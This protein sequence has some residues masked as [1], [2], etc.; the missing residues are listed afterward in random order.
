MFDARAERERSRARLERVAREVEQ[1]LLKP[2]R[3]AMQIRH[4]GVVVVTQLRRR[5]FGLQQIG[6]SFQ[7]LMD[8]HRPELRH[9]VVM[10]QTI[11][12]R[13]E[14]VRFVDDHAG[15]RLQI[16]VVDAALQQ[17][18][19]TAQAGQ[20]I[21]HFMREATQRGRQRRAGQQPLD[22][23]MH[24]EQHAAVE[25]LQRHIREHLAAVCRHQCDAT[26]LQ[27]PLFLQ[28]PPGLRRRVRIDQQ[29][30]ERQPDRAARPHLQLLGQG[31]V[32]PA[33]TQVRVD[34]RQPGRQLLRPCTPVRIAHCTMMGNALVWCK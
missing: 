25:R 22:Q 18:R 11:G 1:H 14:P 21:L 13:A 5:R 17:L 12:E 16:L 24:L 23:R 31:R 2:V 4:A 15:Q 26:P 9:T 6:E 7:Q 28:D 27:R 3:I 34:Q 32:D 19:R 8:V 33:Q 20:R 30:I 10:Q 29:R